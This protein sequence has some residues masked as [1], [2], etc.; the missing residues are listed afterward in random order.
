MTKEELELEKEHGQGIIE[1]AE[2][3]ATVEGGEI[4]ALKEE[5]ARLQEE[6]QENYDLY[7]RALAEQENIKKRAGREREE[8]IK[9]ATLPLIKNL[10]LVID[11]LDRALDVSHANQD[12]EALNKGVEMI[13]RKLHELIKNEGVEAIEAVGKAFDPMYHQP[14]MVEG[15][16]EEQENMVIEEFQKGYIMHGR[17]IRPSLVK[18]SNS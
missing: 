6:K 11:D 12:L 2:P 18:V 16:S 9:F 8:Y 13:A 15:S 5:L 3:S 1:S 14:L 17:V 4:Q 7:L 10:L